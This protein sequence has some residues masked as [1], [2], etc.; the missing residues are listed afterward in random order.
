MFIGMIQKQMDIFRSPKCAFR[1]RCKAFETILEEADKSKSEGPER[2]RE[3]FLRECC[4]LFGVCLKALAEY[5]RCAEAVDTAANTL[6]STNP[7]RPSARTSKVCSCCSS[8]SSQI[9]QR[10]G[11]PSSMGAMFTCLRRVYSAR[12]PQKSTSLTASSSSSAT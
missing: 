10:V 2:V 4:A 9:S 11:L 5:F 12:R 7:R 8:G 1:A 3:V 6:R